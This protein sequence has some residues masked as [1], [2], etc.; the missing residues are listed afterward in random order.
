MEA[1]ELY[2]AKLQAL[3]ERDVYI[4]YVSIHWTYK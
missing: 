1:G 3:N 2:Y 4:K